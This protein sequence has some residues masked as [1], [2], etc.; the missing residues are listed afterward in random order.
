MAVVSITTL[1]SYFE[2]GDKPTEAQYID[3]I[4][5]LFDQGANNMINI[6]ILNPGSP[7]LSTGDLP[8]FFN[9][10]SHLNGQSVDQVRCAVKSA[11]AGGTMQFEIQK[12]GTAFSTLNL[13]T[14]AAA[15]EATS[16]AEAVATGDVITV[17]ITS[18]SHT[19]PPEGFN[20]T[21]IFTT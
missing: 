5:T 15:V 20:L 3:L 7:I 4:D 10:P 8:G 14:G 9:V 12:N 21:L 11:G 1:K 13:T 17:E 6:E 19:T 2:A 18:M 16:I